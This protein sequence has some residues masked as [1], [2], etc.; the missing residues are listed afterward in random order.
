MSKRLVVSIFRF[1]N[2]ILFLFKFPDPD[3][4]LTY[5]NWMQSID[6]FDNPAQ[7]N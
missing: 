7:I 6:N 4:N 2:K 3:F 1:Y 5:K